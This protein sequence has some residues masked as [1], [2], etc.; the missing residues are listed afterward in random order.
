MQ[1]DKDKGGRADAHARSPYAHVCAAH[2]NHGGYTAT[3]WP[4]STISTCGTNYLA[5]G[6]AAACVTATTVRAHAGT[7]SSTHSHVHKHTCAA[8]AYAPAAHSDEARADGHIYPGPAATHARATDTCAAGQS[9]G[10]WAH[11]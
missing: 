11:A 4:A 9:I 5:G 7:P 1:A 10:A 2:A 6:A 3:A 8:I